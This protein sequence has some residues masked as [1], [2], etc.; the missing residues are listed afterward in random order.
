MAEPMFDFSQF[1]E[2]PS[3]PD[4]TWVR[5]SGE[6]GRWTIEVLSPVGATCL[7]DYSRIFFADFEEAQEWLL[8]VG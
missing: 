8:S 1:E 5:T 2:R 6:D 4:A 7:W 3:P